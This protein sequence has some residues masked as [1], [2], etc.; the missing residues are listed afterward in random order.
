MK[1]KF[2]NGLFLLAAAVFSTS[3]GAADEASPDDPGLPI[4]QRAP[5]FTLKNQGGKEVSLE[6]LLKKGPVAVVFYR[7]A[8]WCLYCKLQLIQLQRNIKEIEAS[9]GQVVAISYD[10]MVV[11]KRFADRQKI[12]LPLLS[13]NNSKIIDAYGMRVPDA[14]TEYAGISRHGTFI[15]DQKGVIRAKFSVFSYED[16]PAI[17]ALVKALKEARNANEGAKP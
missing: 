5:A 4:G 2:V 16:R 17:G 6:A 7:S 9:G 10:S 12:T 8:D 11:I 14:T 13:D 3:L 15:L 1:T